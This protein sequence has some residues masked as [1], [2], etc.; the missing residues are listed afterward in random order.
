MA[1]PTV[2]LQCSN[3]SCGRTFTRLAKD[4]RQMEKR[5]AKP[6]CKLSCVQHRNSADGT[7]KVCTACGETKPLD[8]FYNQKHGLHGKTS[9]CAECCKSSVDRDALKEYH[10]QYYLE[11]REEILARERERGKSPE[12]RAYKARKAREWA[13]ENREQSRMSSRRYRIDRIYG[14]T[15]EEYDAILARG[16][17]ICGTHAGRVVGKRVEQEAPPARLCIDHDHANGKIRDALCHSCNTGLG[18]FGD[19]IPRLQS[20]IDYLKQ[21]QS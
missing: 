16:C 12:H 17:A 6:Y 8:Q 9:R 19:D 15:V 20:A 1:P 2:E 21:H 18:S 14:L 7:S 10:R 4:V 11:N 3:P 13:A 5:G